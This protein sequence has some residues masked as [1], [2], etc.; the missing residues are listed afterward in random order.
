MA[1][2]KDY[3]NLMAERKA[4]DLYLNVGSPP[5]A[6]VE[7][8]VQALSEQLL[9]ARDIKALSEQLMDA[10]QQERYAHELEM[11][12][13][14]EEPNLG[15]FRVNIYRQRNNPAIV[16][17][18]IPISIPTPDDLKLPAALKTIIDQKQGLILISGPTNS[19]KSTT[20]ASLIDYR[21]QRHDGH[22]IT[23]EDPIE[24][25][26]KPAKS[27]ISQR[28]IGIDTLSYEIALK[29]ALRQTPDLIM[30]GE[31]RDKDIMYR[32]IQFAQAGNLCLTT[33]HANTAM[34]AMDRTVNLFPKEIRHLALLDLS[35]NL[36][37]VVSQRL[38]KGIDGKRV[39][40]FEVV[41]VSPRIAQLIREDKLI[42]IKD[43]IEKENT[44]GSQ[45]FDG[46][47]YR[48]YKEKRISKEEALFNAVSPNNLRLKIELSEGK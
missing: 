48:L 8:V 38:I 41:V 29:N 26:Y 32:A 18:R 2:I 45:H 27:I 31:V 37:A 44:D 43:L 10:A 19:G 25:V 42:D 40:A 22:I 30:I 7:G 9:T 6:K 20:L 39:A 17:R 1:S 21:N 33:V 36:R 11:N 14:V 5:S 4:S 12:L 28:E 13:G 35:V 23:L 34:H 16:I 3:F 15:S 24:Y 46:D 47:L